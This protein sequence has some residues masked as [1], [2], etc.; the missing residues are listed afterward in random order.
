MHGEKEHRNGLDIV[1]ES[2]SR[3]EQKEVG[4]ESIKTVASS[5]F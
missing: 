3:T 4:G 2:D 1:V 5:L